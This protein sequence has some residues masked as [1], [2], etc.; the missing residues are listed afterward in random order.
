MHQWARHYQQSVESNSIPNKRA[1]IRSF[2]KEGVETFGVTGLVNAIPVL[3]HIS[4][5][6]FMVGIFEFLHSMNSPIAYLTIGI[7]G[8]FLGFYLIFTLLP[9]LHENC[10]YR[11]PLSVICWRI[12]QSVHLLRLR[13]DKGKCAPIMQS[14]SNYREYIATKPSPARRARDEKALHGL[15]ESS[16]RDGD[17]EQIVSGIPDFLSSHDDNPGIVLWEKFQ[18]EDIALCTRIT[19]LLMTCQSGG[20]LS[21]TAR[22]RRAQV[23]LNAIWSMA[24]SSL[25]TSQQMST[26]QGAVA[27]QIS[28]WSISEANV[29][30]IA[31]LKHDYAPSVA[32]YVCCTIA[33]V[34]CKILEHWNITPEVDL[35][36]TLKVLELLEIYKFLPPQQQLSLLQQKKRE[37]EVRRQSLDPVLEVKGNPTLGL[38]LKQELAWLKQDGYFGVLIALID[39][40]SD[41]KNLFI[42]AGLPLASKTIDVVISRFPPVSPSKYTQELLVRCLRRAINEEER[43]SRFTSEPAD[44]CCLPEERRKES[45]S[46][47]TVMS[48]NKLRN[49]TLPISLIDRFLPAV[50]TSLEELHFL[51]EAKALVAHYQEYFSESDTA[52]TTLVALNYK[53]ALAQ[54]RPPP[55]QSTDS[56]LTVSPT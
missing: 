25:L 16:A 17:F 28:A 48:S 44:S 5:F 43:H 39:S 6:F 24:Q 33:V 53:I 26:G 18:C 47:Y 50:V 41:L 23:C 52:T 21:E 11:T 29:A 34:S 14:L 37:W 31:A 30:A 36:E 55:I 51:E 1:R 9:I 20:I 49:T 54:P 7:V 42:L 15:L 56:E 10:P 22:H 27:P 3:L 46:S 12:L 4:V 35:L 2:L 38:K 32:I 40:L 8:V 13:N 19:N 45:F